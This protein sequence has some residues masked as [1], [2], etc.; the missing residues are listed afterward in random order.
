MVM[1]LSQHRVEGGRT[2]S[3]VKQPNKPNPSRNNSPR[4]VETSLT[5]RTLPRVGDRASWMLPLNWKRKRDA[6][7]EW[8]GGHPWS[9]KAR[10]TRKKWVFDLQMMAFLLKL[11]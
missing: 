2:I 5:A 1:D 7:P 6:P 3:Q 8:G 9:N 11:H 4:Y 10:K